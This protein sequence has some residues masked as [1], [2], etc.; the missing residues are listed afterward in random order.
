MNR[1]YVVCYNKPE[2]L[3]VQVNCFNK[4]CEDQ[5]ELIVINNGIDDHHSNMIKDECRLYN[6]KC[7]DVVKRSRDEYCSQSHSQALEYALTHAM[8]DDKSEGL[9]VIMD[10]DVFPYRKFSFNR[11]MGDHLLGGMYQQR[12]V[13]DYIAAIFLMID[14]RLDLSD[15]SFHRGIGDTGAAVQVLMKKYNIVPRYVNHTGQ[16]DIE[17]EYIFRCKGDVPYE[18]RFRSQFIGDAFIHYYRGSNWSEADPEYH[19]QK[20]KFM[21]SFLNNPESYCLNLDE[22]VNYPTA[23]S[24]KSYNGSDHNYRNYRFLQIKKPS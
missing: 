21:L 15:F 19:K 17:S 18:E 10:N 24:D 5:F 20:W 3:D 4:F 6:L 13:H 8:K 14:R 7:I 16:I 9:N 22:Y 12:D 2:F 11:L 23:H 1:V